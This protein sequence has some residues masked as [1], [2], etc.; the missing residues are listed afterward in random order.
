VAHQP[1]AHFHQTHAL[2]AGPAGGTP[3]TPEAQLTEGGRVT[4]EP[5]S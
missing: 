5:D 4:I 1:A 2:G 3:L